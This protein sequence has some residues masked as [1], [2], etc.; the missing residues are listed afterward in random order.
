V[1]TPQPINANPTTAAVR[2]VSDNMLARPDLIL[3]TVAQVTHPAMPKQVIATAPR[4]ESQ[5]AKRGVAV[6]ASDCGE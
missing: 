5:Q 4:A 3:I 6:S 1:R 2:I